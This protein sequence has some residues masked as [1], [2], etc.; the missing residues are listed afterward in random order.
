MPGT[1]MF[2]AKLNC[3]RPYQF[4]ALNEPLLDALKKDTTIPTLD[5]CFMKLE[6]NYIKAK[7]AHGGGKRLHQE[8]ERCLASRTNHITAFESAK[9]LRPL[10][11][12]V[13]MHYC[14]SQDTLDLTNTISTIEVMTRV[15]GTPSASVWAGNAWMKKVG[16]HLQWFAM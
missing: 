5:P 3:R 9:A 16:D 10:L 15:N 12:S 1:I 13:L 8:M 14:N 7:L 4:S 11:D 6:Y 2:I